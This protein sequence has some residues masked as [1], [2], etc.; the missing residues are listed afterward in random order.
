MKIEIIGNVTYEDINISINDTKS[1]FLLNTTLEKKESANIAVYY[2][3]EHMKKPNGKPI[4][5]HSGCIGCVCR[6]DRPLIP[7]RPLSSNPE[8]PDSPWIPRG[9]DPNFKHCIVAKTPK[10]SNQGKVRC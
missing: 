4:M 10:E 7:P 2:V 8:V 6:P 1:F 3:G 9:T 5:G